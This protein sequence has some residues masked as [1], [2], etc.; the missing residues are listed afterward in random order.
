MKKFVVFCTIASLLF[1]AFTIFHMR[2]TRD[3]AERVASC[4]AELVAGE[5]I[6]IAERARLASLEKMRDENIQQIAV[7]QEK[8]DATDVASVAFQL[9]AVN[10]EAEVELK[11]TEIADLSSILDAMEKALAKSRADAITATAD[12]L[13]ATLT[14]TAV[15]NQIGVMNASMSQMIDEVGEMKTI[16]DE[17][18]LKVATMA[19][20]FSK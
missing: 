16:T 7:L 15:R 18:N 11:T 3:L 10:A 13:A 12:A 9:R 17:M 6:V 19:T 2:K 1:V 5:K 4:E 20:Q 14:L 8:L